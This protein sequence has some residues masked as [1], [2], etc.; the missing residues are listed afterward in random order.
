[1]DFKKAFDLVNRKL[2]WHRLRSLGISGNILAAVQSMYADVPCVV[3]TN[4]GQSGRIRSTVGVKQG[5]PLSPTLFGLYIDALEF[6]IN[7]KY[8]GEGGRL[9]NTNI[10]I[11]LF[12]DDVILIAETADGLTNLLSVLDQFSKLSMATNREYY[13]N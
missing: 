6:D 4:N 12:A 3:Q 9:A 13:Q 11:L 5:C 1:M 10:P 7:Q 2:L 8:P